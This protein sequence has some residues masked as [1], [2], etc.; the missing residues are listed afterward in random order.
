M[1]LKDPK[2]LGLWLEA[3]KSLATVFHPE[4]SPEVMRTSGLLSVQGQA[5]NAALLRL[6]EA[7]RNGVHD[8]Q[9]LDAFGEAAYQAKVYHALWPY[10]A[11][12]RNP[13]VSIHMARALMMM[14]QISLAREFLRMSPHSLL[15]AAVKA[16]LGVEKDI[17]TSIDAIVAPTEISEI[18]NLNS[19]EYWQALAP[20]AAAAKR[21]DLV[22]LAERRLKALAYGN[23]VIHYNQALRLFTDGE[24]RAAWKLHEWR[25]VEGSPCAVATSFVDFSMW[26]GEFLES[27]KLLVVMENG[28]GDQIFGLRYLQCLIDEGARI[29]VAAKPDLSNLIKESYPQIEVHDLANAQLSNYWENRESPDFWTYCLSIPSRAD[30]CEPVA[31][32]GYLRASEDLISKYSSEIRRKNPKGL[33]VYGIVWHGDIRTGP[34]RTR[35]YSLSEFLQESG[36]LKAPCVVVCLQKDVTSD[37]LF[38]LKRQLEHTGSILIDASKTLVDFSHTSAW[39]K[40]L[41]RMFSCDTATG[42]LAGALGA[43]ATMLIR[44]KSIWYWQCDDQLKKSYWYSSCDVRYALAPKIS[45]MFEIRSDQLGV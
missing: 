45:Y 6:E 24:F 22:K 20:I 38:E 44:N 18:E 37:E 33:P 12:Y 42:H 35:A 21:Y 4:I 41:D 39:I 15:S 5:W 1:K 31:A 36:V 28:F 8:V 19:V 16:I 32:D 43:P 29:E 2:K 17:E 26:E 27:K 40:C 10:E 11:L 13:V 25:L 30:I 34:M 9:T 3:E 7:V 23:P 14:G